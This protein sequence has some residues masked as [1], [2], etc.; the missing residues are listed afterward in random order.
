MSNPLTAIQMQFTFRAD[1]F[2]KIVNEWNNLDRSIFLMHYLFDFIYPFIY[3]RFFYLTIKCVLHLKPSG[4]V[5]R[6]VLTRSLLLPG[7][8]TVCDLIENTFHFLMIGQYIPINNT[9]T[10]IAA[11]CAGLKWYI[12]FVCSLALMVMYLMKRLKKAA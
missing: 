1:A 11:F 3:G 7:I 2:S 9:A 4:E 12:I 10:G 5:F 6:L 8:V